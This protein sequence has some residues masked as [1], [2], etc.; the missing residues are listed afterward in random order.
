M[1]PHLKHFFLNQEFAMGDFGALWAY[2]H[3]QEQDICL[4]H[5][6]SAANMDQA[7]YIRINTVYRKS[8]HIARIRSVTNTEVFCSVKSPIVL[9]TSLYNPITRV[10]SLT[11]HRDQDASK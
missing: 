6:K 5:C 2:A 4:V 3:Y 1:S 7:P 9:T 11:L 8:A 10:N